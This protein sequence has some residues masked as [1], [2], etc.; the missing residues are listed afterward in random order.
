[1]KFNKNTKKKIEMYQN[2]IILMYAFCESNS[3]H[4]DVIE[5][6]FCNYLLNRNLKNALV[7]AEYY[8]ERAGGLLE[9]DFFGNFLKV[10]RLEKFNIYSREHSMKTVFKD[11]HTLIDVLSFSKV[12][13]F[14]IR[15]FVQEINFTLNFEEYELNSFSSKGLEEFN[16]VTIFDLDKEDQL[17]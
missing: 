1:M 12:S 4:Y 5:D 2:A 3:V 10:S 14:K 11:A 9:D 6:A 8:S 7:D 15:E 17:S 13:T 16:S